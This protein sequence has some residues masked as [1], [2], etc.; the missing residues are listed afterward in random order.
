M[1]HASVRPSALAM[2]MQHALPRH[3]PQMQASSKQR[4]LMCDIAYSAQCTVCVVYSV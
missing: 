4:A 1:L 2:N 3:D